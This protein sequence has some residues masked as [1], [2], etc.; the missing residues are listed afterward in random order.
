[1]NNQL[2][3]EQFDIIQAVFKR[4]ADEPWFTQDVSKQ[5][6]FGRYCL[7]TYQAGV[8]DPDRLF[9]ACL[10]TARDRYSGPG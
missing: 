3:P 1:M 4:V 10:Q 5:R 9:E 2:Q 7:R 6:E 8:T